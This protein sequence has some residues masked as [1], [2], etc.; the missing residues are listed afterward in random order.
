MDRPFEILLVD[1]NVMDLRLM[2][3]ALRE[4]GLNHHLQVAG[5]G[6][7]A[8]EILRVADTAQGAPRPD[9]VLLDLNMPLSDGREVLTTIKSD[10]GLSTIPVVMLSSSREKRDVMDC[11][12]LHANSYLVKP[13]YFADYISLLRSTC[14]Y[15]MAKVELPS[16]LAAV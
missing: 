2:R 3:E 13:Q 11:Y 8:I 5:D 9:L 6:R 7:Q 14:D 10:P 16:R 1:D 12:R 4:L 15:W